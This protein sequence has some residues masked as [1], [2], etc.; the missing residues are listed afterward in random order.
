[1]KK[2]ALRK[3]VKKCKQRM[4]S[5]YFKRY[6][7]ILALFI[8]LTIVVLNLPSH[9]KSTSGSVP[10][11]VHFVLLKEANETDIDFI[12]TTCILAAFFNQEPEKIVLHTNVATIKGKYFQLVQNLLETSL[13]VRKV[14]RPTHVFGYPLSSDYHASDL[15]RIKTLIVEGGI[16][17][18]LDTFL[19]QNVNRFFDYDCT[20]GWPEKQ[21]IGTQIIIAKP[22]AKFLRLWLQ[23]YKDYRASMWY[24]NAGEAPTK[25]ILNKNPTL[26]HRVP[27]LFGV[28]GL[29]KEL[30]EDV[31]FDWQK[32]F[33]IHLLARH[34]NYL[35]NDEL[36]EEF[37]EENIQTYTK[38]FGELARSI[39]NHSKVE[40]WIHSN[41]VSV[42]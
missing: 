28:Q 3:I 42:N 2:V 21:N 33:A 30:Y 18:D 8:L 15:I 4:K 1:M 22:G 24:Y 41:V 23:S 9:P 31:E 11:V 39:W 19:V 16:F 20:L 35:V 29:A 12:S 26:V 10:N 13:E 17:L 38:S 7:P 14:Q 37:N 34:R 32:F 40:K 6:C 25:V 5:C 36:T 27:E